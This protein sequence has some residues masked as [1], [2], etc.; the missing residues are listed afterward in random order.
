MELY[1][2]H[3]WSRAKLGIWQLLEKDP[4]THLA[5]FA[6]QNVKWASFQED[7]DLYPL[8]T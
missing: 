8:D 6:A 1:L 4:S 5:P 3:S 7:A 2:Y